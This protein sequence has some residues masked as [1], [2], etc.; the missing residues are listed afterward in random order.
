MA[1]NK[2][3]NKNKRRNDNDRNKE[4][5]NPRPEKDTRKN[6][7]EE[8]PNKVG[9]NSPEWYAASPQLM[10][11]AASLAF[12]EP[13][14]TTLSMEPSGV[15]SWSNQAF[16]AGIPGVCCLSWVPAVGISSSES[17]ALNIA[18]RNIYSFVRHA[19]AGHTNYN[20]PDLM[21]YLLCMD[22]IYSYFAWMVRLYGVIR[23]Y[24]IKSRYMPKALVESMGVNFDDLNKSLADFR[25]YINNFAVKAGSLCTPATMSYNAR[26][27]WM[28]SHVYLD[29]LSAKGQLYL[30]DQQVYW[31]FSAT[32]DPNGGRAV[33][34]KRY[35]WMG[36]ESTL[37]DIIT[38]GNALLEPI[39]ADEDMGI[40]SGDI[41][42]AFGDSNLVRLANIPEDYFVIPEYNEEVLSQI[43]NATVLRLPTSTSELDV[44]QSNNV[45]FFNPEFS[46]RGVDFKKIIFT[47]AKDS[48]T[49]SDIMVASR[50]TNILL[51][52]EDGNKTY[53]EACGSDFITDMRIWYNDED[54]ITKQVLIHSEWYIDLAAPELTAANLRALSKLEMFNNHP[55]V[56]AYCV[57]NNKLHYSGTFFDVN[58]YTLLSSYELGKMHNTAILSEFAV[59]T[60]GSVAMRG[61]STT[62][63]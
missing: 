21:I 57:G 61:S 8:A 7:R 59:P 38:F 4:K 28:N 11:D 10:V 50:L 46:G 48:P 47:I 22:S 29:E 27:I 2:N 3:K 30:F 53:L 18:T 14:G 6:E 37:A 17:S 41:L 62:K 51:H 15:T 19:N 45:L 13:V 9:F 24:N 5:R 31:K 42:K 63:V 52:D 1:N 56:V 44:Y 55:Q 26:H 49:P 60:M 20:S 25:Y 54:G 16:D 23:A 40:M 36:S 12:S 43:Q 35:D 34:V 32:S 33:A 39:L 58:N